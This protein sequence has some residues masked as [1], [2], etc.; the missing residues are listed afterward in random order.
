[1]LYRLAAMQAA[2]LPN[3]LIDLFADS[4]DKEVRYLHDEIL[5]HKRGVP[6]GDASSPPFFVLAVDVV[7]RA[8]KRAAHP[9][10]SVCFKGLPRQKA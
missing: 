6:Q 3:H 8:G 10:C 9:E 2:G 1:M 7:L 4:F 5:A